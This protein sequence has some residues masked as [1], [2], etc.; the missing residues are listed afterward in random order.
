MGG[1]K[2]QDGMVAGTGM[3]GNILSIIYRLGVTV[4]M[5]IRNLK[6]SCCIRNRLAHPVTIC[7]TTPSI[8]QF[9][10]LLGLDMMIT[11][12][13]RWI[14][15]ITA[16]VETICGTGSKIDVQIIAVIMVLANLVTAYAIMDIMVLIARIFPVLEIFVITTLIL[17]SKSAPIVVPPLRM[18]VW[19]V[20][21]T[22]LRLENRHV[23]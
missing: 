4:L 11:R 1:V 22:S 21:F 10:Y 17:T 23:R 19:T 5:I 6:T 20:I 8:A 12:L 3:M 18:S 2:N 15:R 14:K 13:K 9:I 16:N 7:N